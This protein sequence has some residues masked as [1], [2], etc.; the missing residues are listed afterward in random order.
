VS[1]R[2]AARWASGGHEEARM[3]VRGCPG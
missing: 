2:L 3:D 1:G